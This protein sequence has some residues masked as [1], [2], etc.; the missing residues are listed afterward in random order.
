MKRGKI[1]LIAAAVVLLLSAVFAAGLYLSDSGAD[2]DDTVSVSQEDVESV[3]RAVQEREQQEQFQ[4]LLN[5][6]LGQEGDS[7][8]EQDPEIISSDASAEED[9]GGGKKDSGSLEVQVEVHSVILL[10]PEL[11]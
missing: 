8:L 11:R 10:P 9:A 5:R 1:L 3:R 4:A 2:E 7:I 6:V